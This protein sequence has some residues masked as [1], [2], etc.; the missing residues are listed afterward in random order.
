MSSAEYK[1]SESNAKELLERHRITKPFVDVFYIANKEGLEIKFVSMP[2]SYK[3]VAG[4]F[5][6]ETKTIVV[7]GDDPTNR[8]TFTVAHELGH[9]MLGHEPSEYSVLLRLPVPSDKKQQI[10][11]EADVFA[12]NLLVPKEML[13]KIMR[14]YDLK[15]E[16]ID[17]LS[18]IF[19]VSREMMSYRLKWLRLE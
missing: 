5:D 13:K 4:F 19:G 18:R 1:L 8:Q 11:K 7:N 16:H 10:E 15:G 3:N 12:A 14:E 9:Y 17:I 6:P 2:S